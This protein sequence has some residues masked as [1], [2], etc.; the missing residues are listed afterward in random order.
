[1]RWHSTSVGLPEYIGDFVKCLLVA[2]TWID[3]G[4]PNTSTHAGPVS[5]ISATAGHV[6]LTVEAASN[7]ESEVE[8]TDEESGGQGPVVPKV[9]AQDCM[10]HILDKGQWTQTPAVCQ[11]WKIFIQVSSSFLTSSDN[12]DPLLLGCASV[13]T[14]E[15]H[16]MLKAWA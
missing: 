3:K 15:V 7:S 11:G 13:A 2:Q 9:W 5:I 8:A 12:A 1:M 10:Q 4:G 14:D 6:Q 16:S